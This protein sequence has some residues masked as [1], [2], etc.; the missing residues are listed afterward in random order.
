[1]VFVFLFPVIGAMAWQYSEFSTDLELRTAL[2]AT[3]G[4]W[5]PYLEIKG[6]FHGAEE[7]FRYRSLSTGAYFRAAPWLKIG[8]FYRLQAG[9][10]NIEDWNVFLGPPDGHFWDE[11]INRYEHLIYLDATPRFLL[12]KTPRKNWVFPIKTRYFY[13][14]T[15]NHHSLLIRPGLT[16]VIMPDRRPLV[17]L[18]LNYNFYFALNYGES[19]LYA[20]GPYFSALGHLND[21]LKIEGRI[22]YLIKYYK[23]INDPVFGDDWRLTSSDLVFGIGLIFTPRF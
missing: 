9:A 15:M 21:W 16:Y 7:R 23:I 8:G 6:V 2:M 20:H 1:M 18:T 13:N 3:A 5:N 4:K 12:P 19:P 11:T 10:R 14:F 22:Q 17:N